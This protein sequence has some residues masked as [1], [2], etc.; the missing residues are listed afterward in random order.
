MIT[1]AYVPDEFVAPNVHANNTG[2]KMYEYY[3]TERINGNISLLAK[4]T[5][6]GNTMSGNK[7]TTIKLREN[8]VYIKEPTDLYG[9]LMILAN[10][11]RSIVQR[12]AIGNHEVTLTPRSLFPLMGQCYDAQTSLS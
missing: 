9:R 10:S 4:V 8:T 3:V 5:K 7:T 12:G 6:V 2:Q 1:Q 11:T